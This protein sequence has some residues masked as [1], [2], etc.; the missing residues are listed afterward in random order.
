MRCW[1]S[2]VASATR[3]RVSASSSCALRYSTVR[4]V[5]EGD[6]NLQAGGEA[7][8]HP[9]ATPVGPKLEPSQA[10]VVASSDLAL[11]PKS[12]P[13]DPL[14]R[15]VAL[16]SSV[17]QAQSLH[18]SQIPPQPTAHAQRQSFRFTG[19]GGGGWTS[20]QPKQFGWTIPY[21]SVS[22]TQAG[23]DEGDDTKK[24][25]GGGTGG[26]SGRLVEHTTTSDVLIDTL[27]LVRRLE[28]SGFE[29]EKAEELSA[30]IVEVVIAGN[31]RLEE[32]YAKKLDVEKL[33]LRAETRIKS[34]LIDQLSAQELEIGRLTRENED[35]RADSDKLRVELRYAVDK[36]SSAQRLDMNLQRARIQDDITAVDLRTV[37]HNARL[38]RD[39][40]EMR[41]YI[42]RMKNDV[43]TYSIGSII[44]CMTAVAAL[45]RIFM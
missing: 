8:V 12:C 43:I 16:N 17:P 22:S 11:S 34:A 20:P 42:E 9:T 18:A 27:R 24:E 32:L 1:R 33:L 38:E 29:K 13:S 7:N 45:L 3:L 2:V 28:E 37:E 23:I 39:L 25:D 35:L 31:Q 26:F 30:L 10:S 6:R 41:V 21:T 19:G 14:P 4:D 40:D 5:T 15:V 44:S 36:L